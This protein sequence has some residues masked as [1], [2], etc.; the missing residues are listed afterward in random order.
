MALVQQKQPLG[1][2]MRRG[3]ERLRREGAQAFGRARQQEAVLEQRLGGEPGLGHRQGDHGGIDPPLREIAQHG[4]RLGLVHPQL[5]R[6]VAGADVGQHP[7][8]QIGGHGGDQ[9]QIQPPP[10]PVMKA[11]RAL[12]IVHL[13]KDLPGAGVHLV[14]R[15]GQADAARQ[16]LHQF[17][18]EAG[19][20]FTDLLG[21]RRLRDMHPLGG[22]AERARLGQSGEIAELSKRYCHKVF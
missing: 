8:Q 2:D 21:K 1:R 5:Q 4:G 18:P 19:L 13:R 17:D 12:Q 22:A 6:D 14:A 10:Q 15:A 16:A 20:Q 7:G 3:Q 11:H 9:P